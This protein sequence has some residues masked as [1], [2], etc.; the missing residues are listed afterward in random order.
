MWNR[1]LEIPQD[2]SSSPFETSVLG[3]QAMRFHI[4]EDRN[5]E[6][7]CTWNIFE[8]EL[9]SDRV[10]DIFPLAILGKFSVSAPN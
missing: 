3:Y 7:K 4:P 2:E 9:S 5:S 8:R 10:V 6:L 1:V